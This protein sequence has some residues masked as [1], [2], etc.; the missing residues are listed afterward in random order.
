MQ[1]PAK[2]KTQQ[3]RIPFLIAGSSLLAVWLYFTQD[4]PA[5][6]SAD[7]TPI[8]QVISIQILPQDIQ[9]FRHITGRLQASRTTTLGFEVAGRLRKRALEPGQL[10]T[11]G[12]PLLNLEAEDYQDEVVIKSASQEA[13][14]QATERDHLLLELLQD[15]V[16][17]Q[18][19]E[20]ERIGKLGSQSLASQSQ[21]DAVKQNL[22]QLQAEHAQLQ[23]SVNSAKTRLAKEDA[24]L[25]HARRKLSRTQLIAPYTGMINAVF[26]ETGDYIS[27]GQPAVELVQIDKL[28]L[29]L[30]IP[31]TLLPG[32][33]R[34]QIIDLHTDDKNIQGEI[35]ALS[36]VPHPRT[37]NHNLRIRIN[38]DG[39]YPGQLAKAVLPGS[40]F[41]QALAVPV[42]A[43][44][45]E[46][47]E[48]FIYHIREGYLHRAPVRLLQRH[49]D[50][51]VISGVHEGAYIVARDVDAVQNGQAVQAIIEPSQVLGS[52]QK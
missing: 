24:A 35:I 49:Q 25:R 22:L 41:P 11:E 26:V 42:S 36:V 16:N 28:D 4:L 50:R 14:K 32:L 7:S 52:V 8:T 15:R 30:A 9:T 5:P 38:G 19:I 21:Y 6:S 1:I 37:N 46:G 2:V 13:E 3:L 23:H 45:Y 31:A 34:G 51:Y 17:M 47:G 12:T 43:I 39:L 40:F 29:S 20:L 48:S 18:E 10:V 44:S 27:P 33:H